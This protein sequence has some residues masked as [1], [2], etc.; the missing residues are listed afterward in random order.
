MAGA[1]FAVG[2]WAAF[3]DAA[4]GYRFYAQSQPGEWRLDLSLGVRPAPPLLV[5]IQSFGSLQTDKSAAFPR[6]SWDKLQGS[7]VYDF[8]PVWSAQIGAFMTV[9]GVNA[10]RELG[11]IAALWYRF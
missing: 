2:P 11:P 10:G 5:L 8:T 4:G 6:S 1:N 9:A 7:F 3:A